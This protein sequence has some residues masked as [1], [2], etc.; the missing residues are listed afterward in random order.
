L[1]PHEPSRGQRPIGLPGAR[2]QLLTLAG[3]GGTGF[4]DSK[5]RL[6][7]YSVVVEN[8]HY[9][10]YWNFR[11]KLALG[12]V[13]KIR[14]ILLREDSLFGNISVLTTTIVSV[15]FFILKQ[16]PKNTEC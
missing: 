16:Y 9:Q 14:K 11:V 4:T 3:T 15:Y 6:G 1:P 5:E 10:G 8:G 13:L 7:Y 12:V 2:I